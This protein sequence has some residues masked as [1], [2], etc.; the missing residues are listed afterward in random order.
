MQQKI[1]TKEK[2]KKD[3]F[4]VLILYKIKKIFIKNLYVKCSVKK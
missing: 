1:D 3:K 4:K 2:R